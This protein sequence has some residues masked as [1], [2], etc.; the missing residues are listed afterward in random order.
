[1]KFTNEYKWKRTVEWLR[2]VFSPDVP[3]DASVPVRV[4]RIKLNDLCGDCAYYDTERYFSIRIN[5]SDPFRVQLDTL[6]HEWA[7]TLSWFTTGVDDHSGE[8]GLSY[9]RIYG[10]FIRWNY[11]KG[12]K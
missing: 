4:R 10:A 3:D 1:M 11:G 2:L 8:W 12:N 9:S 7:H 6:I 5:K